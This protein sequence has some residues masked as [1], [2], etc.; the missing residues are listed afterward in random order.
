M[1]QNK[2]KRYTKDDAQLTL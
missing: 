1:I 2:V